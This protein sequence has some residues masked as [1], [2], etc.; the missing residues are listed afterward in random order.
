[1]ERAGTGCYTGRRRRDGKKQEETGGRRG[2]AGSEARWNVADEIKE[3]R[4]AG[5]KERER[6]RQGV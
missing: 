6:A 5:G 4:S 2:E 1:L 3:G